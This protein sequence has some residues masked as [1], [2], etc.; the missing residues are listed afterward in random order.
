MAP[1]KLFWQRQLLGQFRTWQDTVWMVRLLRSPGAGLP[2]GDRLRA[3]HAIHQRL[4]HR[5]GWRILL[6]GPFWP[7][8]H[9]SLATARGAGPANLG[10]D[11]KNQRTNRGLQFFA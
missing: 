5:M 6:P 2:A 3:R 4:L 11:E 10:A 9:E 8:A 7:P 1:G